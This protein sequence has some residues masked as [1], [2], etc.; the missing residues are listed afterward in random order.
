MWRGKEE[1]C[2]WVT[3]AKLSSVLGRMWCEVYRPR[4]DET[5][6]ELFFFV[7]TSRSVLCPSQPQIPPGFHLA[8]TRQ[9]YSL[10]GVAHTYNGGSP[11][12]DTRKS[13]W[14]GIGKAGSRYVQFISWQAKYETGKKALF[15]SLN[16]THSP[17]PGALPCSS[18]KPDE[19]RSRQPVADGY[20][21]RK[22][23]GGD[24]LRQN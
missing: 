17:C 18:S 22:P 9:G 24:S 21:N 19:R 4:D 5:S 16:S 14:S 20:K 12:D 1:S 6:S 3:L 10:E 8:C 2:I 7:T 15:F 11:P 23:L 13:P